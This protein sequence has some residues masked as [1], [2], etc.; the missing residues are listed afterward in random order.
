MAE[1]T[2]VLPNVYGLIR[3]R[4]GGVLIQRRWK[5]DTDPDNLGKWE[6]PGGKWRA[7]ESAL[8]C[9]RRELREECGI[10]AGS[11][12][13]LFS[14]YEH[15]GQLVET[16]SPILVVQLLAETAPSVLVVYAGYSD[17]RPAA[18]GDGA[19]DATFMDVVELKRALRECPDDFT[20]LSFAALSEL[21][22]RGLL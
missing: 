6:L 2:F 17:E 18:R 4:D 16:S 13:G 12:E 9:L 10:E 20:A 22:S 21:V 5:P 15:L 7:D 11:V 3:R 14:R 19:R 8:D 1:E